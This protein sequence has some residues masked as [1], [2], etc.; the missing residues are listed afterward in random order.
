MPSPLD[1]Y[2]HLVH[3]L[4]AQYGETIEMNIYR[5]VY[6]QAGTEELVAEGIAMRLDPAGAGTQVQAPAPGVRYSVV[7]GPKDIL[8]PGD[9]LIPATSDGS[10]PKYTILQ[11]LAMSDITAFKSNK[12]ATIID[13][14]RSANVL[15]NNVRFDFIAAPSAGEPIIP[16]FE[17]SKAMETNRAVIWT[18]E[19]IVHGKRLICNGKRW[20]ILA[21]ANYDNQTL[22]QLQ[23]DTL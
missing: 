20:L 9:I 6:D 2:Q 21:T 8:R 11:N 7:A 12:I 14:T 15:A 18:R 3:S 13:T 23:G 4:T 17:G 10:T 5:G 22:L 19:N 16:E 1:P